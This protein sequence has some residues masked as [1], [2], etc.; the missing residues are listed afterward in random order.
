MSYSALENYI[1]QKIHGQ[2]TEERFSDKF[3]KAYETVPGLTTYETFSKLNELLGE[4]TLVRNTIA[5]GRDDDEII[6]NIDIDSA[7]EMYIYVSAVILAIET[8]FQKL[9]DIKI[10]IKPKKKR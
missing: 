10:H 7:K 3:K 9:N 2:D 5:H 1:N 8:G 6:D 4:Y